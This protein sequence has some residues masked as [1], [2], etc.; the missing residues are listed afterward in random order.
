MAMTVLE[1]LIALVIIPKATYVNYLICIIPITN[2]RG[3][4]L[5]IIKVIYEIRGFQPTNFFIEFIGKGVKG[6]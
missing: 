5:L 2:I 1:S 4:H 6:W 3:S